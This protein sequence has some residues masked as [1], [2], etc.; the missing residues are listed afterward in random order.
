MFS[1]QLFAKSQERLGY[2]GRAVRRLNSKEL[3]RRATSQSFIKKH[4]DSNT[5]FSRDLAGSKPCAAGC[6]SR[7]KWLPEIAGAG[8]RDELLKADFFYFFYF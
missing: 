4:Y 7:R 3:P 5:R 2:L 1:F 6:F 8:Q